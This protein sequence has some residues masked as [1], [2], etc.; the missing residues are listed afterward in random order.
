MNTIKK[1]SVRYELTTSSQLP[2]FG[3]TYTGIFGLR[4]YTLGGM[5]G[6]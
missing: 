6:Y 3:A 4:K 2:S 1:R 5:M